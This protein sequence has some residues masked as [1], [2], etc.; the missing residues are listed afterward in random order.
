M[1][2]I[3]R[4]ISSAYNPHNKVLLVRGGKGFFDLLEQLIDKAESI[5]HFQIY[6]FDSDETGKKIAAALIRAAKRNVKI[7]LLLDGYASRSLPDEFIKQFT[8]T[9]IA[10]RWFEPLFSSN[11]YYFGRRLHHKVIVIDERYS[12]VAGL[13]I[14]NRYNDINNKTA[15]LDFA[16]YS[17]GQASI[18]LHKVCEKLWG[19]KQKQ[20]RLP[21][22]ERKIIYKEYEQN[23]ASVRV[24]RNDWVRGKID[25]S[26]SYIEMFNHSAK[27]ITIVSSYFLPSRLFRYR[28]HAAVKRGVKIKVVLAGISDIKL[29]KY[30]ERYLYTWMLRNNIEVY[31][32]QKTVLHAKV[33]TCDGEWT[34]IGSF[35]INNLSAHAS[36][37][38]NLDIKDKDFV[39]RVDE[40]IHS[41]ITN[42]CSQITVDNYEK[43]KTIFTWFCEWGSYTIV[44]FLLFLFTENLK[45]EEDK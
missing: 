40:V 16:V 13:N 12:L 33:A 17:E 34:T 27:S 42:D 29:S 5:I 31:E 26:K 23:L 7:F 30:A 4:K 10:F 2:F 38:L 20:K 45:Q 8:D 28:I 1:K 43:R 11:K 35:N 22:I 24:R 37:E 9:G 25:I 32:Y 19:F 41:I 21:N 15:W 3:R 6:I 36:I 44:R 18:N 14:S 39:Q